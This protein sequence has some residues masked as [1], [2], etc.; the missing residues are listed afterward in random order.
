M[1]GWE[2]WAG[3]GQDFVKCHNGIK[4]NVSWNLELLGMR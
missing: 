4:I 1:S 2:G 3:I